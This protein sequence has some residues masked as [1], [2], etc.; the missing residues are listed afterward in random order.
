MA[1][2]TTALKPKR[3][4]NLMRQDLTNVL[5][6]NI[7]LY[8]VFGPILLALG[9]RLF[10]PSLDQVS[11]TFAVEAG[12]PA[13]QVQRLERIARVEVLP[14]AAAVQARVLRSDDVP[15]LVLQNGAPTLVLEGN[16]AEAADVL[17]AVVAQ[18]LSGEAV[19]SFTQTRSSTPR[20]LMTEYTT[21]IFF[22]I[23]SLLGALVMAFN[24]I[25]DKETRA[26]RALGVSPLS[27]FELTVARGLFAV[28]LS[29]VI[30]GVTTFILLGP[31]ADYP[32]LLV[33]FLF[34]VGLPVLTGYV[35][36]GLADSQLKAIAILK[37][38]MMIY[39]TLPIITIFLPR[40][41]HVFFYILPNYWMWL[42]FENAV[43]GQ[44]G[45]V[46]F[47]VAG[48]VT[49]ASSLALVAL[50]LPRLRKQLKLR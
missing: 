10:V 47:W 12:M 31:G 33:G 46:N 20:S 8:M 35:I 45:P 32:L 36:G 38:Y 18:A 30:V 26:V 4:L 24:I 17:Q 2:L 19:A 22:M 1:A 40:S 15:G 43:I 39:L 48:I 13:A 21:I 34:A 23:G 41:W 6:D 7:L 37:F 11:F 3:I 42:T 27:M 16:E 28:L 25:E 5:R 50:L 9:A 44:L 49:L 14:D 29:L